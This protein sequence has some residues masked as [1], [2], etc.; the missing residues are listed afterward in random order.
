MHQGV[1]A[2]SFATSRVKNGD[3]WCDGIIYQ[4]GYITFNAVIEAFYLRFL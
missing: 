1:M 4:L 3:N 2:M